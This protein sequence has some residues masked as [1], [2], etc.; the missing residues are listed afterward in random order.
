MHIPLGDEE[1]LA[2]V[3]ELA[4]RWFYQFKERFQTK[5]EAQNYINQVIKS[6]GKTKLETI[7]KRI[8]PR[9]AFE[10]EPCNLVNALFVECSEVN[11]FEHDNLLNQSGKP[12]SDVGGGDFDSDSEMY[13][14][15]L[16]IANIAWR[17]VAINGHGGEGTPKQRLE[18]WLRDSGNELSDAEIGRIAAV[19][20][21]DKSAVRPKGR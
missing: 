16:D 11:R 5:D 7:T 2:V 9:G 14:K 1:C 13:P 10:G 20:N 19:C 8:R 17:A 12:Q 15:E 4:D 3:G 18:R 6:T 21:W